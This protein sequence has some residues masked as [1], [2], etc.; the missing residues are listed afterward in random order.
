MM[1]NQLGK[2][3]PCRKPKQPSQRLNRE[4]N[5]GVREGSHDAGSGEKDGGDENCPDA[6]EDGVA[7][8]RVGGGVVGDYLK[9]LAGTMRGSRDFDGW[10][11]WRQMSTQLRAHKPS[12]SKKE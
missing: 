7:E 11:E 6:D 9:V 8:L 5:G 1:S 12:N 2:R 3:R 4:I 10:I